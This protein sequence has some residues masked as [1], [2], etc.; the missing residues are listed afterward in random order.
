MSGRNKTMEKKATV[1]NGMLRLAF[2]AVAILLEVALLVG[3]FLT[4]LDRYAEII[5]VVSRILA[6]LLVL[7]IYS[8][9]KTAS[10]KMPCSDWQQRGALT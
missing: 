9:N 10:I 5:A 6:L 8:Q 7:G 2:A 3:M 1:K 4:G